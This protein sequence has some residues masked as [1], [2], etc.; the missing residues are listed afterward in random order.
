MA[1]KPLIGR[2]AWVF[3][4]VD[5]DVDQIV[6]VKNIKIKDVDELARVAM[7]SRDPDLPSLSER[8]TC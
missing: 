4:E 6:G 7:S 5:F 8:E 2:A 1:L 3:D